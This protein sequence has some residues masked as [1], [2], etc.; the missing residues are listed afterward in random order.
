LEALEGESAQRLVDIESLREQLDAAEL[1]RLEE[2]AAAKLLLGSAESERDESRTAHSAALAEIILLESQ[3]ADEQ[4]TR[5]EE[6]RQLAARIAALETKL[7]EEARLRVIEVAASKAAEE[8]LEEAESL[9]ALRTAEIARLRAQ[10]DEIERARLFEAAAAEVLLDEL[11]DRRKALESELARASEEAALLDRSRAEQLAAAD[12]E[13]QN[14]ATRIAVLLDELEEKERQR[15]LEVAAAKAM[16]KELDATRGLA[17][18]RAARIRDLEGELDEKE[19]QRLAEAAAAAILR[20]R[21]QEADG[22]REQLV[23][24]YE[25]ARKRI[26]SLETEVAAERNSRAEEARRLAERIA[27]LERQL[28]EKEE[29]RLIEVAAA[30]VLRD[31]LGRAESDSAMRAAELQAL[32]GR[33]GESERERLA[34]AA[35]A[36]ILSRRIEEQRANFDEELAGARRELALLR[37]AAEDD[38]GAH[39]KAVAELAN[40]IALLER[41]I[42]EEER[43]KLIEIAAARVVREELEKA[44]GESARLAREFELFRDESRSRDGDR[45]TRIGE[46]ES[47]LDASER[48]RLLEAAA[49]E[50][51]RKRLEEAEIRW[52]QERQQVAAESEALRRRVAE[53]ARREAE[54]RA[55]LDAA[56]GLEGSLRDARD[57]KIALTLA[58]DTLRKE[59]EDTLT[60]LAAARE[61]EREAELKADAV[62]TESER[63]DALLSVARRELADERSLSEESRRKI[64]LLN[65]Q[66]R[67][68]RAQVRSLRETLEASDA[69]DD[70]S[71]VEIR[72]LGQRLNQA[73]AREA[74]EKKRRLEAETRERMRLEEQARQL[75]RYRSEFFGRLRELVEG[76]EGVSVVGDRFLLSS[77]VLFETSQAELSEAGE[78]QLA[79]IAGLIGDLSSSIPEDVDWIIRVDG[80][81]DNV[82]FAFAGEYGDNWELSQGRALAVVRF[83]IGEYDV[84]ERRLA[85]AGFGEYRPISSNDTP[86]G[87]SRNRRIEL[88]LTEP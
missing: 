2:A 75:E 64:T 25:G 6:K 80:H 67:D 14:L 53:L 16:Q 63:R 68:L 70:A 81:T 50:A 26:E 32:E 56:K 21:L 87:R 73:L 1:R 13:K 88:K 39:E 29:A 17:G 46:L 58:I 19:R 33:L 37:Q 15:L 30:Q 12:E 22:R 34:E 66:I 61:A 31:E 85:A 40:R 24:E 11:E 10:L 49:A 41:G 47:K 74:A 60:M 38:R 35:A 23:L 57:E 86:E 5:L 20:D 44:K 72:S 42:D 84:P 59:A 79:G 78:E 52:R 36:E 3:L 77:E 55:A 43:Q 8:R 62:L 82:P 83:L 7:D 51:I 9:S 45:V 4:N 54:Q 48:K 69:K 71:Q 28:D 65:E 76:R 18:E 27:A